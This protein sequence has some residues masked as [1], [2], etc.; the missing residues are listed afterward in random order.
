MWGLHGIGIKSN[1]R[2]LVGMS[3]VDNIEGVGKPLLLLV[4]AVMQLSCIEPFEAKFEDFESAIVV[5]A[6]ITDKMENQRVFLTRSYE[7][8]DDGPSGENNATVQVLGGGN[9]YSFMESSP[10]VYVSQQAFAAA[11]GTPYQLKITTQDGRS[12]SSDER[13]LTQVTQIDQLVAKRITNDFGEEG[14]AI[15]VDSFDP[16]GNS[17]NYRYQYE[18]TYK[19][20]AP[21]WFPMGLETIPIGVSPYPC[22]VKVIPDVKSKETCFTTDFSNAIIQTNTSDLDE[23]RVSDFRVRFIRRD[24]YII[25]HRY[26]ILVRQFVQSNEAFTFYKT[27][28]EFSE[29]DSFFSQT[30]PGFLEG[31]ILSDSSD[32]EKVLGYFDVASVQEERL[33][34]NYDDLF[35]GEDLPPY[36]DPCQISSPPLVSPSL[37]PRCILSAMVEADVVRLI[38]N[39]DNP[40]QLEGPYEVVPTICGDC[41]EI[42]NVEVPEF[43]IE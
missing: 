23:D 19:I 24:N 42:G 40:G 22:A 18:E 9:T 33:F 43:W 17:A 1:P 10:G 7:F 30:Q 28:N 2:F 16:T 15:L 5:E 11:A 12:Y 21:F 32:G 13:E 26:S 20:I 31:N 4:L 37:P 41:L 29:N 3:M 34:F 25:S 36:A 38:G 14:V 27:L 39:N 6:T 35:P 8:E